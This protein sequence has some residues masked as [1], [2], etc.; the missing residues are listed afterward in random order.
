V[1]HL[2]FGDFIVIALV[3]G[4]ILLLFSLTYGFGESER[5]IEIMGNDI[6]EIIDV[7]TNRVV[8]VYG[9][10]GRTVIIVED[11]KAWV[12]DSDCREKICIK[13]GKLT[14]PG[15]QAVCLP[16]RVIVQMKGSRG[17]VDGV[18]R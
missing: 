8:E 11:G 17:G 15:E 13:M 18:S 2:K 3:A 9:P 12:E 4:L 16:N 5:Q 6:H 14:R 1:K 7:D 10:V